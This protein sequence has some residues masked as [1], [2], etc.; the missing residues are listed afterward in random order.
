MENDSQNVWGIIVKNLQGYD[1]IIMFAAGITLIVFFWITIYSW[2]FGAYFS[3]L[4]V[5]RK[6][7]SFKRELLRKRKYASEAKIQSKHAIQN[8]LYGIFTNLVSIFPL[9]GM[10][11]TVWALLNLNL[12]DANKE[13]INNFFGALTSTF[14]G[15]IIG[16]IFKIF[17]AIPNYLV[18]KNNE[19]YRIGIQRRNL[20]IKESSESDETQSNIS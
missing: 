9:L 2:S 1:R 13:I 4:Y 15:A 14:W 11:G 8:C 12:E 6:E 5:E 19:S 16:I 3:A 10:I 20:D 7:N 17:D 18:E